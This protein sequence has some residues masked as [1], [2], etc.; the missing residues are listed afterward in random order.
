[1]LASLS[2]SLSSTLV[3]ATLFSTAAL[4]QTGRAMNLIGAPVLGSTFQADL[5]YPASAAG[6]LY[7]YLWSTPYAG[8][9]PVSIP[10]LNVQGSLRVNP[11]TMQLLGLGVYGSSGTVGM[12]VAVPNSVGLVG[13][14]LD[15]Q[16]ADFDFAQANAF[17]A[18]NDLELTIARSFALRTTND[19]TGSNYVQIAND[20]ALQ[21][22]TLTIDATFRPLGQGLGIVDQFGSTLVAKPIQGGSGVYIFSWSL[23][24]SSQTHLV[25]FWLSHD[26]LSQGVALTGTTPIALGT[27]ARA[28]A[29]MDGST[30]DL[31]VDG[32]LEA[33]VAWPFAGIYY[34]NEDVLFGAANYLAPYLRRFDGA[35]DQVSIWNRA[36]TAAEVAQ[37]DAT[38]T[39][40]NGLL[41]LWNFEQSLVD[42]TGHGHDGT[43]VGTPTWVAGR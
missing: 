11:F 7:T 36:M 13:A 14:G 15:C 5:T 22:Q 4:A 6:N 3:A 37:I 24:W 39:T 28:T 25:T 43:A 34:G 26:G 12:A 41:G 29:T 2:S 32:I 27:W 42:A 35:L 21:P 10:G 30:V 17:L 23:N 1:M 31:Y 18:D 38:V 16:G 9:F 40:G 19:P 8:S 20:P 33:S